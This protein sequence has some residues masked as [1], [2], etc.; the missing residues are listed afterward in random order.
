[1]TAIYLAIRLA[2]AQGCCIVQITCQQYGPM[3]DGTVLQADSCSKPYPVLIC[4]CQKFGWR[5]P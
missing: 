1:M 4:D 2:L 3:P 5:K